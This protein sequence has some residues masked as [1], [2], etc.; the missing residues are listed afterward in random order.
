GLRDDRVMGDPSEWGSAPLTGD[1]PDGAIH[2][3]LARLDQFAAD[4][5][6]FDAVLSLDEQ[7]RAERFVFDRD[8]RRFAA[9]RILLRRLLAAYVRT[10]PADLRFSCDGY[11]KP[12]LTGHDAAPAFNV[13][14]SG[15]AA[16]FAFSR[17][18]EVGVDDEAVRAMT[19]AAQ[20]ASRFFAPGEV[21]RLRALPLALQHEAFFECW[22][23]KE[24]F[25][26]AIG[27]GL[28][29]PLDSFEVTLT[30][31]D[32]ARLVHVDGHQPDPRD[33][34]LTALPRIPGHVGALAIR[35]RPQTIGYHVWRDPHLPHA[36]AF[37]SRCESDSL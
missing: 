32:P 22:T 20:I 15:D 34:T 10:A 17:A 8:R 13:S 19:D 36:H 23:R 33:W 4:P 12:S 7:E 28:S 18:G 3:W 26:K 25:V 29:H 14:H 1:L 2:V 6:A 9:A 16:V 31:G 11:G 37:T 21:E 27:E 5:A 35:G 30:P 24:A